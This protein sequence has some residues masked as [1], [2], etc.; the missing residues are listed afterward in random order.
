[1]PWMVETYDKPG[2][3]DLRIQLRPAHLAFLEANKSLLLACG[4]KL[5]DAGELASGGVYLLDLESRK[6]AQAFIEQDPFFQ[7]GLFERVFVTQWRK[8]YL[9]GL[10]TL[11]ED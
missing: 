4:A 5:D 11:N 10:N 9:N 1:M 2:C 3:A 6:D 7:G 8:A